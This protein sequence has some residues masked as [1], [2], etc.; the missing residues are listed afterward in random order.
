MT[1][2]DSLKGTLMTLHKTKEMAMDRTVGEKEN[3]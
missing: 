2:K 3:N 1:K